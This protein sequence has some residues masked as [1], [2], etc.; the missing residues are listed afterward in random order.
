[1]V[2]GTLA[3]SSETNVTIRLP[4]GE[5]RRIERSQIREMPPPVSG[6][7]P[8]EAILSRRELRDTV[9]YLSSLKSKQKR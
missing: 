6:M 7:P 5:I 4:E 3:A 2:A 1:V 8:M 9:A